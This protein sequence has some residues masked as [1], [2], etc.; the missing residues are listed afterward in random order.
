MLLKWLPAIA[1]SA[2]LISAVPMASAPALAQPQV[3]AAPAR[4]APTPQRTPA[5]PQPRGSQ[6]LQPPRIEVEQQLPASAS[7][8][9]R[10]VRF[11][12]GLFQVPPGK[13]PYADPFTVDDPQ[14]P[15]RQNPH[16]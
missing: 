4:A 11:L 13:P 7:W 6:L 1:V 12:A 15:W 5:K 2:W 10:L 9:T 3:Q 16:R 8:F 14:R